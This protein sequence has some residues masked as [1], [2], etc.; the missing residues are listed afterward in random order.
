MLGKTHMAVGI[1]TT[2]AVLPPENTR[3]LLLEVGAGAVGALISDIDVGTSESHRDADKITY[4]TL[5]VIA[6]VI[7]LDHFMNTGIVFRI[8]Q[9]AGTMKLIL[10]ILMFVGICAYGKEQPH[11][12]FMH[13][14]LAL[15]LLEISIGI[16]YPAFM[17][18]FGIGF[19]SHL[20]SDIF[21]RRK[22]R[23]L[24]PIPGGFSLGL[25]SAK[26]A[27]NSIFLWVACAVIVVELIK[28]VF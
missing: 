11:R 22:V 18:S 3:Q 23:L 27:A 6:A 28:F 17:W 8:R 14:F 16:I 19:L 15:F 24:Y 2:L 10:G 20:A 7:A 25:F 21:N 9:S 1:A 26:G 13:S 12:S 4:L 5:G